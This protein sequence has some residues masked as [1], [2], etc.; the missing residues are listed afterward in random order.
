MEGHLYIWIVVLLQCQVVCTNEEAESSSVPSYDTAD[1]LHGTTNTSIGYHNYFN[2]HPSAYGLK[3]EAFQ[4]IPTK[5]KFLKRNNTK[6]APEALTNPSASVLFLRTL[7]SHHV[8]KRSANSNISTTNSSMKPMLSVGSTTSSSNY[9]S[10]STTAIPMTFGNSTTLPP[11]NYSSTSPTLIPVTSTKST[12]PPPTNY[13]VLSTTVTSITS[14]NPTTPTSA[15][16]ISTTTLTVPPSIIVSATTNITATPSTT[17]VSKQPLASATTVAPMTPQHPSA[18]SLISSTE[19]TTVNMK[20]TYTNGND[21]TT[22]ITT[23]GV[24]G[25]HNQTGQNLTAIGSKQTSN[26]ITGS[27]A[28]R[29]KNMAL[30][31]PPIVDRI[32]DASKKAGNVLRQWWNL[33][34]A[35]KRPVPDPAKM[36]PVK[37]LPVYGDELDHS[38]Y[39][40]VEEEPLPLQNEVATVRK[41]F[42]TKYQEIAG[43]FAVVDKTVESSKNLASKTKS[44]VEAEWTVLPKAAAITIGGMAGFIGYIGRTL[45][46]ALGLSTMA[47]FCYPHESIDLIREGARYSESAWERFK[48]SPP[49]PQKSKDALSPP[50]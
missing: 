1:N 10:P 18:V 50:V 34:T 15:V 36:V 16:Q 22:T 4:T 23:Q 20:Q 28:I 32:S 33:T 26:G 7:S 21:Q 6:L 38:S 49:P 46:T 37:Q 24:G 12:T 41:A 44:Y 40:F 25:A 47:A 2:A 30:D 35:N 31:D 13:S 11:S 14:S 5:R 9:S 48:N 17:D 42:M 8:F 3:E 43:R 27:N 39:K 19:S 45:Y 29:V